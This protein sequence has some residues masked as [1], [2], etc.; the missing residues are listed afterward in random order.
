MEV[1]GKDAGDL[2]AWQYRRKALQEQFRKRGYH[3]G[4]DYAILDYWVA[5]ERAEASLAPFH[6]VRDNLRCILHFTFSAPN[7]I[8][9]HVHRSWFTLN[10]SHLE[11]L[12]EVKDLGHI[13]RAK[14]TAAVNFSLFA[15]RVETYRRQRE[16]L[17]QLG[18][19]KRLALA[20]FREHHKCSY[21]QAGLPKD[22]KY[23]LA[24]SN[25]TTGLSYLAPELAHIIKS[26]SRLQA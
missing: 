14:A 1:T 5:M 8:F 9:H 17:R 16:P 4:S 25:S 18:K 6:P 15:F 7:Q 12:E 3:Y 2:A 21:R 11:I 22:S 23:T 20:D 24:I 19:R 26:G 10:M 13:L